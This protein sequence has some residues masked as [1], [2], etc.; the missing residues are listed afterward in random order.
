MYAKRFVPIQLVASFI[1]VL[2][3]QSL[4]HAVNRDI[5]EGLNTMFD[6]LGKL[7]IDNMTNPNQLR[8]S[9]CRKLGN[10]QRHR[11]HGRF[12]RAIGE[13]NMFI[14][15]T[16]RH[17]RGN[18]G[19]SR[20]PPIY[21]PTAAAKLFIAEAQGLILKMEKFLEKY[22]GLPKDPGEAGKSTL[23]GIDSDNDGVRDDLQRYMA[24]KYFKDVKFRAFL[25]LY[26]KALQ[27][28][29]IDAED[30]M[31]S[32]QHSKEIKRLRKCKIYMEL[33]YGGDYSTPAKALLA[34]KMNTDARSRAYKQFNLHFSGHYDGLNLTGNAYDQK[35]FCDFNP[36]KLPN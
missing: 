36:D 11:N 34:A 14:K 21:I 1:I 32:I 13:L 3:S 26:A 9:L 2:L 28:S 22:K 29:L 17:I 10:A 20:H 8:L 19:N 31:L 25:T 15:K 12:F 27:Q 7:V 24:F 6:P 30:K 23:E 18:F 35:E 33:E 4:A 16:N 5:C